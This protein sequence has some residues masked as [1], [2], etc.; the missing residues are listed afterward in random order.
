M[1]SLEIW[2]TDGGVTVHEV[3]DAGDGLKFEASKA[4]EG[5]G[6]AIWFGAR[7]LSGFYKKLPES[8]ADACTAVGRKEGWDSVYINGRCVWADDAARAVTQVIEEYVSDLDDLSAIYG[9]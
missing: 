1:A 6:S 4:D 5:G 3:A 2:K 8:T 7:R 9:E